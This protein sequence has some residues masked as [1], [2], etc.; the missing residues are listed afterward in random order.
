MQAGP[1]ELAEALR[2]GPRVELRRA[3]H[4]LSLARCFER[5]WRLVRALRFKKIQ[6][7]RV[8]LPRPPVCEDMLAT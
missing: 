1:F 4:A 2:R 8:R 5:L 3:A 7:R 6:E